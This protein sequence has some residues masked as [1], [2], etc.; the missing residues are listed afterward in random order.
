[1]NLYK[2]NTSLIP[3]SLIVTF[4]MSMITAGIVNSL[5]RHSMGESVIY[6]KTIVMSAA[7]LF[8][9]SPALL[10]IFLYLKHKQKGYLSYLLL[11]VINFVFMNIM[12]IPLVEKA[13]R[14][15]L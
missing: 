13:F 9:F 1:M 14:R 12:C 6:S 15:G 4:I 5:P 2:T 8:A 7:I 10:S 11:L 3:S